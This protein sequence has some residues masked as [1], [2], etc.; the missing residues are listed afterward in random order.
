M[1]STAFTRGGIASARRPTARL[2]RRLVS[3]GRALRG[4]HLMVM[5]L[6][7]IVASFYLALSLRYDTAV[8]YDS[9]TVFLPIVLLTLLVRPIVN[10]R[11]G[12]YR[13][14]WGHA[15]VPELTQVVW[16]MI[17]GTVICLVVFYGVV[18]PTGIGNPPGFPRSFWILE[19]ILC[20]AMIG[21]SRFFIRAVNELGA[22]TT[23]EGSIERTPALLFGAGRTGALMARS[24]MRESKAGVNP[25][26]FLDADGAK[27]GASVA[28]L[29]VFGG[30][31]RL[32]D[33][34]YRTG[35][36]ML[37]ITMPNA[38]GEAVR[39]VMDRALAAGLKVRIVPP[40]YELLDGSRNA[41][42][43]REVRLADLLTRQQTPSTRRASGKPS[44][45]RS[46]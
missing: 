31:D 22:R 3:L 36:T 30:L 38:S 32:D 20:L 44:T 24:A 9:L 23:G 2:R 11:F 13:R 16:A 40:V 29:K 6:L 46:C 21:G 33:A 34:V 42:R 25:V 35:A 19:L 37:L 10:E 26:G 28:G 4:R 43:V 18:Q 7:A 1:R 27:R 41:T 12:L 39:V 45:A 14:A 17:V 5:D 8:S 15:S